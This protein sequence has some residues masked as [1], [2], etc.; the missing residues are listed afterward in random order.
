MVYMPYSDSPSSQ[1]NAIVPIAEMTV[2]ATKPHKRWKPPLTETLAM[3]AAFVI[4][5]SPVI[6]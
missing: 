2:E 5:V 3:P 6:G 4:Y 1:A